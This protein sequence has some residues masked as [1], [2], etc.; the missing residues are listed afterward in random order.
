MKTEFSKIKKMLSNLMYIEVIDDVID[1]HENVIRIAYYYEHQLGGP[2]VS[3]IVTKSYESENYEKVDSI[4]LGEDEIII[5]NYEDLKYFFNVNKIPKQVAIH[6]RKKMNHMLKKDF[7]NN[8]KEL[9]FNF[10]DLLIG[11]IEKITL[12]LSKIK[13]EEEE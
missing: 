6:K 7:K 8:L 11:G 12:L 3:I 13:Y 4:F 5:A 10:E 2:K 1:E 9:W